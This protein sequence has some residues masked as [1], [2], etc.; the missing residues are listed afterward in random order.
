MKRLSAYLILGCNGHIIDGFTNCHGVENS[1]LDLTEL[2]DELYIKVIDFLDNACGLFQAPINDNNKCS[3]ILQMLY[4]DLSIIDKNMLYN[5]QNFI[6]LH[7]NCGLYLYLI[8]KE[9][10]N[11]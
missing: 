9:D 2:S 11:G 5:I 6:R 4:R 8:M 3:N 10:F 1:V 7:K